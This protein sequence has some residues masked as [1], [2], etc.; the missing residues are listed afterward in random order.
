MTSVVIGKQERKMSF[1][2]FNHLH[3]IGKQVILTSDKAPWIW[4]ILNNVCFHVSNGDF[5]QNWRIR[6]LI[7]MAIIKNKHRD[8]VEMPDE[9]TTF[10][11]ENIKTNIRELE[12]AII[13][14][15]AHSSFNKQEVTL[16]L[17]QKLLRTTYGIRK[18]KFPLTTFR[19]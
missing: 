2:I 1:H 17:A 8:G 10:L 15:I 12:G 7:H 16:D 18:E 3:Q 6:I 13:S 19:K 14:L 9:I 5:R 11:A 4:W